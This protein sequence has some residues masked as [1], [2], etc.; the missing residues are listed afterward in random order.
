MV[1]LLIIS[2]L[3]LVASIPALARQQNI[4][5]P[6]RCY[7][8]YEVDSAGF[9]QPQMMVV[10]KSK[11][12]GLKKS[13]EFIRPDCYFNRLDLCLM[14]FQTKKYELHSYVYKTDK[15]CRQRYGLATFERELKDCLRTPNLKEERSLSEAGGFAIAP[16]VGSPSRFSLAMKYYPSIKLDSGFGLFSGYYFNFE[17]SYGKTSEVYLGAGIEAIGFLSMNYSMGIEFRA[18]KKPTRVRA[19][20][21][22][23]HKYLLFHVSY[24]SD[25]KSDSEARA[26][27]SLLFPLFSVDR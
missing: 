19:E 15:E 3:G 22:V 18:E 8:K 2:V 12:Q 14:N 16:K 9:C 13:G 17:P 10:D 25:F 1:K 7:I 6:L 4:E 20:V 27:M 11:I 26:S 21:G 23:G 5:S 24:S